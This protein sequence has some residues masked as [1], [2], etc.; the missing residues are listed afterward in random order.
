MRRL[1]RTRHGLP[2]RVKQNSAAK[3]LACPGIL[4]ALGYIAA[5]PIFDSF[6]RSRAPAGPRRSTV[7]T[8]VPAGRPG[9]VFRGDT[10]VCS[11]EPEVPPG[12]PRGS[13][14]KPAADDSG[15]G[16]DGR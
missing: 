2:A 12:E 5:S 14:G 6:T 16:G 13:L 11:K 3:S 9:L 8:A 1:P 4:H 10:S 15:T 7:V